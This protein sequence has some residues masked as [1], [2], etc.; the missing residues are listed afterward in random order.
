MITFNALGYYGRLGNQMFQYA[1]TCGIAA[2]FG[3]K[4]QFPLSN[5]QVLKAGHRCTLQDVF[6]LPPETF[7]EFTPP[8]IR[9][10]EPEDDFSAA[11]NLMNMKSGAGMGELGTD[12]HGY[13]QSEDYFAHCAGDI[14]KA[15][16]FQP[17]IDQAANITVSGICNQLSF[18]RNEIGVMHVR[19]GDY[20]GLAH[21]LPPLSFDYYIEAAKKF[22][23]TTEAFV[24]YGGTDQEAEGWI[25]EMAHRVFTA[26]NKPVVRMPCIGSS[27]A[28]DLCQM[29]KFG[30]GHIIANSSFSWWAAWLREN[31]HSRVVAP[32][33]WFGPRGPKG[34]HRLVPDRWSRV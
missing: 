7:A 1:S 6:S 16:T 15:F 9:L 24:V 11:L 18:H 4:A 27:T 10:V 33:I 19:R 31:Q 26:T 21:V 8:K 3:L 14:R 2:K 25:K 34:A 13:F 22:P 23:V 20:L 30:G 17:D 32:K 12:L 29:T 28:D 5:T